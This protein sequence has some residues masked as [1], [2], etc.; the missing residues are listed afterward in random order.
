M[1]SFSTYHPE[2]PYE[3]AHQMPA[4]KDQTQSPTIPVPSRRSKRLQARAD[5]PTIDQSNSNENTTPNPT[6][7]ETEHKAAGTS[8]TQK[9]QGPSIKVT[10]PNQTNVKTASTAASKAAGSSSKKT[11]QTRSKKQNTIRLPPI[12]FPEFHPDAPPVGGPDLWDRTDNPTGEYKKSFWYLLG[13]PFLWWAMLDITNPPGNKSTVVTGIYTLASIFDVRMLVAHVGGDYNF[14]D[15]MDDEALERFLRTHGPHR[16]RLVHRFGDPLIQTMISE[17]DMY[18][19]IMDMHLIP[20]LAGIAIAEHVI[21]MRTGAI[22]RSKS[23]D[24]ALRPAEAKKG[25]GSVDIEVR[26]G[27]KLVLLITWLEL[28]RLRSLL[29]T[30]GDWNSFILQH[31]E[32]EEPF[33]RLIASEIIPPRYGQVDHHKNMQWTTYAEV[34]PSPENVN[35]VKWRRPVTL[36][37]PEAGKEKPDTKEMGALA[38]AYRKK[39]NR[40]PAY[41][42]KENCLLRQVRP[43]V[44]ASMLGN[45]SLHPQLALQFTTHS[46]ATTCTVTSDTGYYISTLLQQKD[47]PVKCIG[48][49]KFHAVTYPCRRDRV[50][51]SCPETVLSNDIEHPVEENVRWTPEQQALHPTASQLRQSLLPLTK[52]YADSAL[53][54]MTLWGHPS[55]AHDEWEAIHFDRWSISKVPRHA[56]SKIRF[57]FLDKPAEW[58][59]TTV[60]CKHYPLPP[61]TAYTLRLSDDVLTDIPDLSPTLPPLEY[62]QLGPAAHETPPPSG[63]SGGPGNGEDPPGSNGSGS[64]SPDV[65]KKGKE[66]ATQGHNQGTSGTGHQVAG[67]SNRLSSSPTTARP[68]L[69][70]LNGQDLKRKGLAGTSQAQ[71]KRLIMED[72]TGAITSRYTT[73]SNSRFHDALVI[74]FAINNRSMAWSNQ[75]T[76]HVKPTYLPRIQLTSGRIPLILTWEMQ[77]DYSRGRHVFLGL[78]GCDRVVVKMDEV[79]SDSADLLKETMI[80][81][82][83]RHLQGI[84]IPHLWAVCDIV[85]RPG[86]LLIMEYV[87]DRFRG[88]LD[89]LS[90]TQK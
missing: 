70:T 61:K 55:Q 1:I 83:L 44:E 26:L 73:S 12:H 2:F 42:H 43:S 53:A 75:G 7:V 62:Q 88:T 37:A 39:S 50:S 19:R 35:S 40:L 29:F 21:G 15:D 17:G 23:G 13:I 86:C 36:V 78:L 33:M 34:I 90:R 58:R 81:S 52:H 72:I 5:A 22:R 31:P 49:S 14:G 69:A 9:S 84:Y 71:K 27:R 67:K 10:V 47:G 89:R 51:G 30:D 59:E 77:S 85:V 68:Y 65:G 82:K 54:T 46:P 24:F 76:L 57:S 18:Q 56:A 3:C 87:G 45:R 11:S 79:N 25:G 32:F 60:D 80:Y 16:S 6:N 38:R 8:K 63:G 48:L 28:K 64:G 4:R 66:R 74:Q 20:A 41:T